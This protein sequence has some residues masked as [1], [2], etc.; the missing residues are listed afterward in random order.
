[1]TSTMSSVSGCGA[2]CGMEMNV[3]WK[4][5][6]SSPRVIVTGPDT[7]LIAAIPELGGT[8]PCTGAQL[9]RH[10]RVAVTQPGDVN[11]DPVR[12]DADHAG[13]LAAD[14]RGRLG[15]DHLS[16]VIHRHPLA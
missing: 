2:R 11:L 13:E 10:R 9:R 8:S 15:R 1:M 12:V 3:D 4:D 14:H 7:V 16:R 5:C 6:G